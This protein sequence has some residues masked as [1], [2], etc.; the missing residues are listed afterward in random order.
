MGEGGESP[1]RRL[2]RRLGPTPLL[3]FGP[4]LVAAVNL[5]MALRLVPPNGFYGLRTAA[6]LKSPA[7][8]YAA[9]FRAGAA[10][11]TLGLAGALAV[12]ALMRSRSPD[13]VVKALLAGAVTL[14][15]AFGSLIAGLS[16]G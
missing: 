11:V 8:W 3:V 9:N 5:P 1:V 16:A 14:L 4:L 12:V 13:D 7:L 10:G 6:T 2:L 15:V